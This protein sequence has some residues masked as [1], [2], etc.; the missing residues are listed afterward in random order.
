MYMYRFYFEMMGN[1]AK[2]MAEEVIGWLIYAT[3][4]G[5]LNR[6]DEKYVDREKADL[7]EGMGDHK[8]GQM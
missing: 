3:D 7:D 4:N 2:G 8:K 1:L 5:Y 6:L